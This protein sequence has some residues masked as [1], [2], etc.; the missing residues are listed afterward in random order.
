MRPVPRQL[1][2]PRAHP[3]ATFQPASPAWKL[4]ADN[5]RLLAFV[6]RARRAELDEAAGTLGIVAA[7]L[8]LV[9][10]LGRCGPTLLPGLFL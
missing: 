8:G 2:R 5:P 4:D 10:M 7:M 1:L 6:D 9:W 3:G